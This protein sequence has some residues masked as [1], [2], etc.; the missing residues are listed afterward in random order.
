MK[1]K[2]RLL[3]AASMA[4]VSITPAVGSLPVPD[5]RHIQR[6]LKLNLEKTP[7]PKFRKESHPFKPNDFWWLQPKYKD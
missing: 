2:V 4:F 6:E 5:L 7:T 3:V 1:L